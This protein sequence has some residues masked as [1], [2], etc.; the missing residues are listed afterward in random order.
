M[1]Y[2]HIYEQS[3]HTALE[4]IKRILETN[5]KPL[6]AADVPHTYTDNAHVTCLDLLGWKDDSEAW[7]VAREWCA[8]SEA[9]R[10][11]VVM[12]FESEEHCDF[13]RER[14]RVVEGPVSDF[15]SVTG[16]AAV[17]GNDN[18]N[19]HSNN[20]GNSSNRA[21]D[22]FLL[23]SQHKVVTRIKEYVYLIHVR[24]RLSLLFGLKNATADAQQRVV[25][26]GDVER[27]REMVS[28]V[29]NVPRIPL[30]RV[31]DPADVDDTFMLSQLSGDDTEPFQFRIDRTDPECVTPRRNP[32]I[33]KA[34]AYF[35]SFLSW[36]TQVRN[37]FLYGLAEL[38]DW[39][40]VNLAALTDHD[41]FVPVVP[42]FEKRT[43]SPS[44]LLSPFDLGRFLAEQKQTLNERFAMVDS[45]IP[46]GK[47]ITA[48]EGKL[49]VMVNHATT[50]SS[51]F[52][53]SISGTFEDH[54]SPVMYVP[55]NAATKIPFSGKRTL[56]AC[57]FH[58]FSDSGRFG[59]AS[60]IVSPTEFEPQGALIVKNKDDL[61]IPLNLELI[62]TAQEFND[63]I[64]S[65]SL[66][67]QTFAKAVRA[68]QLQATLFAICH[69]DIK[70][71][72]ESL[73]NLPSDAPTKE[74]K[75]TQDLMQLFIEHQIPSDLLRFEEENPPAETTTLTARLAAV[76]AYTANIF[77]MIKIA[78]QE[79]IESAKA[80]AQ[81]T[82]YGSFS[83]GSPAYS[84][85]SANYSPNSACYSPTEGLGS[86][87]RSAAPAGLFG[88]SSGVLRAA[89]PPAAT[90]PMV[91]E[92][93][94]LK[95]KVATGAVG[96]AA[97]GAPEAMFASGMPETQ[98]IA[99]SQEQRQP[100]P[101]RPSTE[102]DGGADDD[103]E[104]S[105]PESDPRFHF[106]RF[107][108]TLDTRLRALA[109][110][111]AIRPTILSLG[112]AWTR[113][114]AASILQRVT[115]S[116]LD[117]NTQRME[118]EAAFDLLDALSRSG[119]VP[120]HHAHLHFICAATHALDMTL[121]D[122]VV[123]KNV[124]PFKRV[125]DSALVMAATVAGIPEA[126]AETLCCNP[127]KKALKA[128]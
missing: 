122:T 105:T 51:I 101:P 17:L 6:Y 29:K 108:T 86:A 26:L 3:V 25:I 66:E 55:I 14:E 21:V 85:T 104:N 99:S 127:P 36:A 110:K 123:Q 107:P 94:K 27:S 89:P 41:T 47:I 109:S 8:T 67:Q 18:K 74:I 44:V 77:A 93:I 120:L 87:T 113:H 117:P 45:A 106:M 49:I 48:V 73:F 111:D 12:R 4:D 68:L 70:P 69:I 34:I 28:T 46:D 75:L 125:R 119:T 32:A 30:S 112:E 118:R 59:P 96:M 1:N 22:T 124:N 63:A 13:S 83:P 100:T 58:H 95:S 115:K 79:E 81:Q 11:G 57:L 76:K 7:R 84:I 10:M 52:V 71:Q 64:E 33:N 126:E 128:K 54:K 103:I 102:D 114:R 15:T 23:H 9:E 56:H 92:P 16:A 98:P 82:V 37:Y 42:L 72:L 39:T 60:R 90:G 43:D 65:L 80:K 91:P 20:D 38:V 5:R 88:S 116:Q 35:Y 121:L 24:Y 62:P 53:R 50:L 2:P 97:Q 31:R 61:D 40:Q 19:N 78:G